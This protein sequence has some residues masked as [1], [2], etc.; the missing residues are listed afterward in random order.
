MERSLTTRTF[1]I[2]RVSILIFM[3]VLGA[4]YMIM[5]AYNGGWIGLVIYA[6]FT[7]YLFHK[8]FTG[9]YSKI[10]EVSYD[11]KSLF[12]KEKGYEVQIPF[13]QVKDVEIVSLDGLYKFH[14]R[15]A[16]QFGKEVVCKP[17]I[18][19]PLNYKRVDKELNR[20]RSLVRKAHR[21]Y[22]DTELLSNRLSS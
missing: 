20:I 6:P 9:T 18:W 19:Y 3:I 12:V 10:K 7:A 21:E 16:D 15:R 11:D 17:S 2:Y 5:G 8:F 22:T 13:H 4:M 14:L 1:N